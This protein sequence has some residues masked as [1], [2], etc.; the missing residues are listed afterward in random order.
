MTDGAVLNLEAVQRARTYVEPSNW[1]EPD[2]SVLSS[3]REVPPFPLELLPDGWADWVAK[4][5]D[6]TSAPPDYVA[7]PLLVSAAGL[8]GNARCVQLRRGWS[9]PCIL[10]GAMIGAPS[11]GKTPGARA[12][13][14]PVKRIEAG[15]D[16]QHKEALADYERA[17][18]VAK[19]TR[20]AWESEVKEAVGAGRQAPPMPA[21]ANEPERP[22]FPSILLN[23]ST[24]E[25]I[26]RVQAHEP[27]G[28]LVH[29][30]ELAGWAAKLEAASGTGGERQ[31]YIEGFNAGSYRVDRAKFRGQPLR[32]SRLSIS[33]LGG[34]QPDRL[35]DLIGGKDDGL[36]SR[37]LYCWPVP[38]EGVWDAPEVSSEWA[39]QAL[40]R[41]HRA[42]LPRDDTGR[43]VPSV[44][45]LAP[46]AGAAFGEW[47]R[48]ARREAESAGGLLAG[49]LG[50]MLGVAG[51][52]A[53][54]WE[55]LHWSQSGSAPE[56]EA[57]SARAVNSAIALVEDYFRAH[58]LAAFG[59]AARP[60]DERDA[61]TVARAI[62]KR[63]PRL[64]N[65]RELR[66][67]WSLEG[68][69]D[70]K[71]LRLALEQLE[72]GGWLR[73]PEIAETAPGRKAGDFLVNPAVLESG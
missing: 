55:F 11:A 71:R 21:E 10:W 40:T 29:R 73:A 62:L 57:V 64:V 24:Q 33:M 50:K 17:A 12:V 27:R 25:A 18:E 14:D 22:P 53:L 51:R 5:A 31:F 19:A 20:G 56:P 59:D 7:L 61:A 60:Q 69:S 44:V 15:L 9:E 46:D 38:V 35:S 45:P 52:L 13:L 32:I 54:V 47:W 1:P 39:E 66:R 23:D 37:F 58:A 36:A 67:E 6:S 8:I 68:L 42:A 41:L 3:R 16:E 48:A 2:F 30:D 26:Q 28:V 70:S 4:A 72:Q 43:A 34:V 63:K 49:Q 65:K